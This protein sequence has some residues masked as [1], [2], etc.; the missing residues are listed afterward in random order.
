LPRSVE[1]EIHSNLDDMVD[2]A[3]DGIVSKVVA[4]V[5]GAE[6]S[7]FCMYAGQSISSHASS[8][9]AILHVLRGVGNVTLGNKRHDAKPNAWF[10]MPPRLPH[11]IRA[12]ENL[13]FLLAVFKEGKQQSQF[14]S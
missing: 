12:T 6:F 1:K 2:F 4:K 9:P 5:V 11:A 7:L 8:F 14:E 3:K 10:Y 13:V